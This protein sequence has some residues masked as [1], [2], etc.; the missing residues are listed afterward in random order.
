MWGSFI[1]FFSEHLMVPKLR[2]IS[3]VL[4][5][6]KSHTNLATFLIVIKQLDFQGGVSRS[7]NTQGAK[8]LL[9]CFLWM[10][11][12]GKNSPQSYF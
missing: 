1:L 9:T 3:I 11:K 10:S 7:E 6:G 2:S 4:L 12:G 8:I 5:V